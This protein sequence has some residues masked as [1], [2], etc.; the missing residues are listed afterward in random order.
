MQQTLG[1]NFGN[2]QA[3]VIDEADEIFEMGFMNTIN[4]IISSLPKARQTILVSATLG[5]NVLGLGKI[6][7]KVRTLT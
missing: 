1:F 2:L 5:K 4:Q 3:L 7:L 6:A